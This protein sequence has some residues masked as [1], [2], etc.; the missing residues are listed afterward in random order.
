MPFDALTIAAVRQELED[1]V[2]GGRVQNVVMPGPLTVSLELYR[3]GTGRTNLVL[4]AHPQHARA[5]LTRTSASR[6]PEQHPPLLLLLRKY[7]RGGTLLEVSQPR[8]ERVLI[9]SIA[10][11]IPPDKHQ[12]YH[13]EGDFMD[14]ADEEEDLSAPVINVQLVAEVMGRVSNIVLVAEDGTV[15]DSMKRVPSSINRYRVTL[16]NHLYVQPPPQGKRDPMSTSI[17]ALSLELSRVA[18]DDPKAPVWKGL[19]GGY[20]AVSPTLARETAYRAFGSANVPAQDV[21]P[22]PEALQQLLHELQSLISLEQTREWQ[23]TLAVKHSAEGDRPVEF[24]PYHLSHLEGPDTTVDEVGSIS[25]AASQY[26][27]AQGSLGGHS[28]YRAQVAAE[29]AEVRSREA[30]KLASL[31]QEWGRA[32]SVEMIRTRGEM[33]LAYMHTIQP[34]QRALEVPGTE[35][36]IELDPNLTPVEQ[37]QAIFREYRKARAAIERLPERIAESEARIAYYDDL[38]TAL[39]LASTYDDIRAVLSE[40][41]A[42]DRPLQPAEQPKRKGRGKEPR[43]PQPLRVQTRRGAQMLLGRTAGQNDTAT[44]RLAAPDD[45]WFHVRTGPGSHVILRA[46]P[47]LTHEDIEDAARLAAGYS[48]LREDTQVDVVYTERRHVR[49][50]PNGPPGQATYRNER[51]IRVTPAPRMQAR[52]R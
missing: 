1:T 22:R 10:K 47:D 29:L 48:K 11:R 37:S 39:D 7:V 49:R 21:A 51:V 28:A 34:G 43:A 36:E 30:R 5:F 14:T 52:A 50:I 17:N 23:P 13:S 44:F 8:Y 26:F 20:A 42:A 9:L 45:L 33:L 19:V 38:D 25:E 3:G 35:I 41:A 12:E 16:P 4:S 18:E 2:V 46:A 15:M 6:D 40:I 32:Q 31:Q 27:D 24:A